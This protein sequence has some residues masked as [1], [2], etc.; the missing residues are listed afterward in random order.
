LD[1]SG[2]GGSGSGRGRSGNGD[3]DGYTGSGT[4]LA[5]FDRSGW[6]GWEWQQ[7]GRDTN[8]LN[9]GLTSSLLVRILRD[10][11]GVF[12]YEVGSMTKS[13]YVRDKRSGHS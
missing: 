5:R 4:L 8:E 10:V 6:Y 13:C 12:Y 1:E 3:R 7:G 11:K 2:G 9:S